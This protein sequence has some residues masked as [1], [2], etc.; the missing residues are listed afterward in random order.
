M[1]PVVII[2]GN[3]LAH[4]KYFF[5]GQNVPL[6]IME[7]MIRE[8]ENWARQEDCLVDLC[9]DPCSIQ[10]RNSDPLSIYVENK[11]ADYLV[12]ERALYHTYQRYPCI[13]VTVDDELSNTVREIGV[14]FI[15]SVDFVLRRSDHSFMPLP[16]I[17]NITLLLSDRET[18][19]EPDYQHE[20]NLQ[21]LKPKNGK[22]E[23]DEIHQRT[24]EYRNIN[25][26]KAVLP[27]LPALVEHAYVLK[28][29]NWPVPKGIR[30]IIESACPI[31]KAQLKVV[32]GDT[33]G[34]TK[35]DMVSLF[36]FLVDLCRD[37]SDF[38]TRGGCL[39]DRVRLALIRSHPD[40][41]TFTQIAELVGPNTSGLQRK[42]K[43]YIPLWIEKV[44]LNEY[45]GENHGQLVEV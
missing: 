8:L 13:V 12:E 2:D 25:P 41:L 38:V 28:I 14:K 31:H 22:R 11:K 7:R 23:L 32:M 1:R 21:H 42:I 9:L 15:N 10:P 27:E 33:S 3:N 18:N 5:E 43:N 40:P 44:N 6:D 16:P 30:F 26:A 37:E 19:N 36:D 20:R 35:E 39:M 45:H 34:A 24:L 4:K 29:S 17:H